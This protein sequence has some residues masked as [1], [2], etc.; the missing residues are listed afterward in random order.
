[1]TESTSAPKPFAASPPL[2]FV[3]GG[4]GPGGSERQLVY[5][6]TSLREQGL[7][8]AVAVWNFRET[9]VYVE[10]IH[11]SGVRLVS[12]KGESRW[13]KLRSLRQ[14]IRTGGFS[15]VQS[16]NFYL[17]IIVAAAAFG[18]TS[19]AIGCV[20]STL[21][22]ATT[23]SGPILARLSARWPHRQVYNNTSASIE[24]QR[25]RYWR[26]RSIEVVP[27]YVDVD[28][29]S[30]LPVPRR[31]AIVAVGSLL[32]V[33]RWDR[34]VGVAVRLRDHGINFH[35]R[36]AGDGPLRAWLEGEIAR[37]GLQSQ[38]TLHG[39]TSEVNSIL[40]ESAFLLHVSESEGSP[41]AVIEALAAGRPVV[42]TDV[43]DISLLVS[44]GDT[45]FVVPHGSEQILFERAAELLTN[46]ELC[47][48]MGLR[49][50][51]TARQRFGS[52]SLATEMLKAYQKLGCPGPE[53]VAR[54]VVPRN[55]C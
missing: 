9:D 46:Y 15:I 21:S 25:R 43:G 12:I 6:V 33:K 23:E 17:N 39:Y 41:N 5:L 44:D 19:V 7:T 54:T 40:A 24:A 1:M 47:A 49:A 37:L 10:A 55:S 20:R 48:A 50:R 14:L 29:F 27:N 32:P 4:L 34:V 35:M 52:T 28:A 16:F 2:L 53:D 8:T 22:L 38:I 30:D 51:Q 42:A 36:I 26:P 31:G 13:A 3:I 45:G 11:A 18:T